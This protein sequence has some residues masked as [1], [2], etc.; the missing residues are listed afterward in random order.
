MS[1]DFYTKAL[2]QYTYDIKFEDLPADVIEKV[3]VMTMHTLAASLASIPLPQAQVTI[4]KAEA[5]GGIPEAT[6]WGGKCTK[7]P[8]DEAAFANGT[9]ADILDWEDCS[10]AGHPSAGAIPAAFAVTEALGKSG[11]DYITAVVAGME[12]YIRAAMAMQPSEEFQK[13]GRGWGLVSWQIISACIPAAKL[14]GFD[15]PKIQQ[16]LGAAYHQTLMTVNKHAFGKGKCDVYHYVHG[17]NARNGVNAA[18]W[19]DWGF[20]NGYDALDGNAGMWHQLSDCNVEE[21]YTK[22]LGE[23]YFL[24]WVLQKP[25]PANIWIQS[26]LDALDYLYRTEKFTAG[27][28]K[29]IRVSPIYDMFFA[30]YEESTRGPLDA[31]F[32]IPYC[33]TAYL[34]DQT[35]SAKWFSKEARNS[36]EIV[37]YSKRIV[38]FKNKTTAPQSFVEF[39]N[40]SFPEV[41]VEID[42]ADGRTISH[43]MRYCKGHPL[44]PY[45]MEEECAHF[46]Q[47]V[48]PIL[49][50]KQ[51]EAI[52]DEICKLDELEN[53]NTLAALTMRK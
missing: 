6:V 38:G 20:Y 7:I 43:T 10:W 36:A 44:N 42:L 50:A 12:V 16:A 4:D 33:F 32:S 39:R 37:E 8:M 49:P 3:K 30:K 34:F 2:S 45:T 41:T 46:R 40:R 19:A 47:A 21:W 53:L 52:I 35:P 14:M 18:Q 13:S 9:L 24:H 26:P 48:A 22:E 5:K 11:K 25:W 23:T 29:Q 17:F 31:Q 28:V 51:I 15:V 27:D 1:F